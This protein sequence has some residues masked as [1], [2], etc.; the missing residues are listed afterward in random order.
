MTLRLIH[1]AQVHV[2]TF[3][4]LRDRIAPGAALD[5]VVRPDWLARAR[6]EGVTADLTEEIAKAIQGADGPVVCTCT[7]L[8][9]TAAGLGAIRI[10]Q[11]MMRAAAKGGGPVLMAYALDSTRVPSRALLLA[12]GG[13]E[14]RLEMLDLT[15]HWPLFE[16]GDTAA[17]EQAI[18]AAIRARVTQGG[19]STVVLAQASMAGA[20]DLL[21]DLGLPVLSSPES[22]LRAGLAQ[23]TP[24]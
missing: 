8:G 2:Q 14:D 19:V 18:A 5:H 4:A 21:G 3:D 16:S 17:F 9:E 15:H 20:A 10:D 7:T 12:E 6:Q 1:T 11:P 13:T 24:V 22:A 23:I